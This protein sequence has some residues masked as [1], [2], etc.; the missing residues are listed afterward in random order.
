M[1][2]ISDKLETWQARIA[3]GLAMLVTFAAV[4]GASKDWSPQWPAIAAFALAVLAWLT[5]NLKGVGAPHPHDVRLFQDF[6]NLVKPAERTFLDTQ[7]FGALFRRDSW[8]GIRTI[9]SDWD[10]PR[11][12]FTHARLQKSWSEVRKQIDVFCAL[13]VATTQPARNMDFQTVR[14]ARDLGELSAQTRQEAKAMNDAATE[15]VRRLDAFEHKARRAL[16]I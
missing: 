10:G 2:W 8:N 12:A 7:D 1:R 14:T 16:K 15:L 9:Y 13:V 4:L 6:Q 11:Y 3:S 5:T